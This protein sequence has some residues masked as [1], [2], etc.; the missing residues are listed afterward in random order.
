MRKALVLVVMT[1]A[2]RVGS[3][4]TPANAPFSTRLVSCGRS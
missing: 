2:P 4:E 3:L 1:V